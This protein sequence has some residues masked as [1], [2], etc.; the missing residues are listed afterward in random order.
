MAMS[1]RCRRAAVVKR[2]CGRRVHG[3][4][5]WRVSATAATAAVAAAAAA[6]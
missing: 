1:P 2:R 3:L 6:L 4:P 5:G